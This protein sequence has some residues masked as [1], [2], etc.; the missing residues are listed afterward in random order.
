[1]TRASWRP[2]VPRPPALAVRGPRAAGPHVSR[3]SRVR[4]FAAASLALAGLS[5]VVLAAVPQHGLR[6]GW[7]AVPA[8]GW[9]R[10]L[11]TAAG[12]LCLAL[13]AGV[14][15]G[16][17]EARWAG[18]AA[19]GAS[20]A[21]AVIEDADIAAFVPS[22]LALVMMLLVGRMPGRADTR[23]AG[24]AVRDLAVGELAVLAYAVV[25][26]YFLD[27]DFRQSTTLGAAL[28]EGVRTIFLL[29]TAA[30]EPT[31]DHG[32]WFLNSIRWLSALTIGIT[33]LRGVAPSLSRDRHP[34]DKERVRALLDRWADSP[35]A[36]F[37]LLDDK[38]WVLSSDENAFVGYALSGST[39]VALGGP[40]GAPASRHDA[41]RA[42][43]ATCEQRG[44]SPAF[45]SVD[46]AES[47]LLRELGLQVVKIG[48]EAI[49]D[50]TSF[51]MSGKSMKTMRNTISR[52]ERDGMRVEQ[53][54][55]PLE[56]PLVAE[57]QSVSDTWLTSSGHRERGFS[58]GAF[59]AHSVR[60]QPVVVVRD[61]AGRM[62]AFAN[63][64]PS[65]AGTVGNFDL[66]R[67]LPDAPQGTMELLFTALI[68]RFRDAGLLTMSLG[69]APLANIDDAGPLPGLLRLARDRT[70]FMNFSGLE[71]FKA[72]WRPR[73]EPRFFAYSGSAELPRVAA[74]TA[75]AGERPGR[76]PSVDALARL[77]RRFA[78]SI[79]LAA[80]ITWVMAASSGDPAYHRLLVDR[81][82]VS[83]PSLS[84]LELWRIPSSSLVQQDTGWVV[85]ITLLLG[86]LVLAEA[87]LGSRRMLATFFLADAV[88]TVPTLIV[89][90]LLGSSAARVAD[91]PNLGSSAGLFG[92]LAA[93]IAS[94]GPSRL[95]TVAATL[96]AVGLAVAAAADPEVTSWQHALAALVGAA[97]VLA[98]RERGGKTSG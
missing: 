10:Y 33:A 66:M 63:I 13:V 82:A 90:H 32:V 16:R 72:K 26:L 70:S 4:R 86:A 94:L 52:A 55:P 11:L 41:V 36:P 67:R 57:L 45:H 47:A 95:R 15:R 96:L 64:E 83:W 7:D 2:Q 34:R 85:Q 23:L 71:D 75:L 29:P 60:E 18:V 50:L 62:V 1:M 12:V 44:W 38:H 8:Y 22:A 68:E 51:S 28:Q 84:G 49:I 56:A 78:G 76:G 87:R 53:P 30:L 69:L 27:A 61:P 92:V 88:A 43:L 19:A 54:A 25:G 5:D 80:V 74:S 31:T 9:P 79:A 77:A 14:A 40:V 97:L 20:M 73:W 24:R 58:V 98:R 3:R 6:L 17:R 21:V 35:L 89:L 37:H 65:F 42:F 59:D 93:A 39:A 91:E 46:T 48:E 81:F